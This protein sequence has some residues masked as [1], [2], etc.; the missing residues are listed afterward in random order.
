MLREPLRLLC[1]IISTKR[2]PC[3]D[4]NGTSPKS[5]RGSAVETF[6]SWDPQHGFR[7][8]FWPA[9]LFVSSGGRNYCAFW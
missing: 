1:S 5:L 3:P 4:P 8:L 7:S 2:V 9:P 6:Q